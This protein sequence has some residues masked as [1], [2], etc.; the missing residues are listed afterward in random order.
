MASAVIPNCNF[1]VASAVTFTLT[2]LASNGTL[3]LGREATAFNNTLGNTSGLRFCGN[4]TA[5]T[6]PT[7]GGVINFWFMDTTNGT[8]AYPGGAN[9]T[10]GS[11]SVT[12]NN[13]FNGGGFAGPITITVSATSNQTYPVNIDLVNLFGSMPRQP[14]V[15][16]THNTGVALNATAS[17]QQ[18]YWLASNAN[19]TINP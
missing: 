19:A 12:N 9:G 13:T 17:F 5:G 7:S 14:G 4:V 8:G 11:F 3:N 2:S 6:G 16:C 15:F 18:F 1:T 10:D